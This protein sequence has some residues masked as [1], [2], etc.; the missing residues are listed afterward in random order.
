MFTSVP[1]F[2]I[3]FQLLTKQTLYK[4]TIR[5]RNC[6]VK[7]L[8]HLRALVKRCPDAY[9]TEFQTTVTDWLVDLDKNYFWGVNHKIC[10]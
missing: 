7:L 3:D 10:D 2:R 8:T 5:V 9:D 4:G 6:A 1:C